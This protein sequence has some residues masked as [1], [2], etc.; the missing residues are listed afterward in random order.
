MALLSHLC[1]ILFFQ[2][3]G[4]AGF[5][6]PE[7]A[8]L[9]VSYPRIAYTANPI[10]E[11]NSTSMDILQIRQFPI[12]TNDRNFKL[13]LYNNKRDASTIYIMKRD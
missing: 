5:L 10:R 2:G 13:R 11:P 4:L 7:K 3:K 1:A 8:F 12:Q 9:A 6:G